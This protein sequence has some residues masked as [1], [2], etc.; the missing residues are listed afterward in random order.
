MR[1]IGHS[2]G[3]W[4]A[5]SAVK[6]LIEEL[7]ASEGVLL[8]RCHPEL[9][10][11]F[12][13]LLRRGELEAVLPGAYALPGQAALVDVRVDA[14]RLTDPDAILLGAAAARYS[15][16]P[17]VAV[18][19][20]SAA[21]A[22]RREPQRGYRFQRR[23]IPEHLVIEKHGLRL[24]APALTAVELC[25]DV[26][27]EVVDRVL[28]ERIAT[29]AQLRAALESTPGR[30]HNEQRRAVLLDSRDEPW[31]AAERSF[32][33]LLRAAGITGWRANLEVLVD[34][35]RYFLD[36][37]FAEQML[38][39]EIDGRQYHLDDAF[40]RDRWRQNRLVLAGWRVLR[41][42][43]KMLEEDAERV[44]AMVRDALGI[45]FG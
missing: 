17:T 45:E 44:I 19:R 43:W 23:R 15:F 28:R 16:W 20:V 5:Y 32:H 39:I 27:G 13:G 38:A 25:D 3:A 21:V 22:H 4:A 24:S 2:K 7:L 8:R 11:T 35:C 36:V 37:G 26:G 34:G 14:L 33:R 12:D 30:R 10:R 31:S 41:F 1:G 6:P 40:E 42:T 29:L 9:A 18:D